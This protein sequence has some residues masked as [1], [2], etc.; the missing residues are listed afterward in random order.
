VGITPILRAIEV[1]AGVH[2]LTLKKNNYYAWTSDVTVEANGTLPLHIT[3][4]PRY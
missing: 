4:S 3:L 1:P 2:T